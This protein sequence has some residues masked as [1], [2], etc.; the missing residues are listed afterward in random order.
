T[1][2]PRAGCTPGRPSPAQR[3]DAARAGRARRHRGARSPLG[4]G[5]YRPDRWNVATAPGV[6]EGA[7]GLLRPLEESHGEVVRD[8]YLR[9]ADEGSR[10]PVTPSPRAG[11]PPRGSPILKPA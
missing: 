7:M 3:A 2:P 11:T 8:V 9:E 6:P 5:D 1:E 10:L 4:G